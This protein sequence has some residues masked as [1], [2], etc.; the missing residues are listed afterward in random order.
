MTG[1]HLKSN[2]GL[3]FFQGKAYH[4][5]GISKP[6]IYDSDEQGS[7]G[8]GEQGSR[9]KNRSIP[10]LGTSAPASSLLLTCPLRP[11]RTFTPHL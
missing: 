2:Q 1:D 3:L 9:G 8:A 7:R 6:I 4:K 5:N 10:L 11:L